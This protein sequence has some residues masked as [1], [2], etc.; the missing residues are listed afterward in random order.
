MKYK[1]LQGT[2]LLF[3]RTLCISLFI[4]RRGSDESSR[5]TF[6]SDNNISSKLKI[7][8]GKKK[9]GIYC[10]KSIVAQID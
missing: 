5:E 6:R 9:I 3:F 7:V 2:A 1:H 4:N 10:E 8:K